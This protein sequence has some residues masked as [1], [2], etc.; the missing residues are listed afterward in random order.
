MVKASYGSL[1][2]LYELAF[3][4][5]RRLDSDERAF[6]EEWMAQRE[7]KVITYGALAGAIFHALSLA[8][9]PFIVSLPIHATIL[10]PWHVLSAISL[11]IIFPLITRRG[12]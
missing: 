5:R 11:A 2:W 1:I 4:R 9:D 6:C 10:R 8:T 12:W 7:L 3:A